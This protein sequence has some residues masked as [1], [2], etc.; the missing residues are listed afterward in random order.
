MT[1]T[2]KYPL[3][4]LFLAA[5]GGCETQKADPF[6]MEEVVATPPRMGFVS[7]PRVIRTTEEAKAWDEGQ[8]GWCRLQRDL[9]AAGLPAP[10]PWNDPCDNDLPPTPWGEGVTLQLIDDLRRAEWEARNGKW[11][12]PENTSEVRTE[13]LRQN[14]PM[15]EGAK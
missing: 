6:S 10:A 13:W 15:G 14:P 8:P 12:Q 2:W 5:L 4:I 11:E 7:Y 3:A 9:V 1:S